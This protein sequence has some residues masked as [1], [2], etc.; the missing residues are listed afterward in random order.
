MTHGSAP[1]WLRPAAWDPL[2]G[3]NDGRCY[4]EEGSGQGNNQLK[5]GGSVIEP[6]AVCKLNIRVESAWDTAGIRNIGGTYVCR[7]VMCH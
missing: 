3:Q 2:L 4:P 5:Y 6:F 1:V 7:Y